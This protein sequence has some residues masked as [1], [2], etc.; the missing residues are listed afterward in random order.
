MPR[1]ILKMRK[2][3]NIQ[4]NNEILCVSYDEVTLE[5]ACTID[6]HSYRNNSFSTFGEIENLFNALN[7]SITQNGQ[8]IDF[9]SIN[10]LDFVLCM[11]IHEELKDELYLS[12]NEFT[13]FTKECLDF[14]TDGSGKMKMPYELLLAIKIINKEIVLNINELNNLNIK[15]YEKI[16][17]A[18]SIIKK[19]VNSAEN[20]N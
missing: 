3:K 4:Y 16:E 17:T 20:S 10:N 5:K 8:L 19:Q 15:V 6:Y 13:Q 12:K 9:E 7:I 1:K 2:T 14:L 18:K 11:R